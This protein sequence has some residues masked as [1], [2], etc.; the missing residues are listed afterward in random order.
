MLLE[1]AG[2]S[3]S[4]AN[5][6]PMHL[7]EPKRMIQDEGLWGGLKFASRVIASSSARRRIRG[8]RQ[9]FNRYSD[10]INAAVLIAVKPA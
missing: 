7:L 2:F 9:A 1:E 4:G 5:E 6:A 10:Y 3:V 8:I